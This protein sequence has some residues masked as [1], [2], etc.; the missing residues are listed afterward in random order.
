MGMQNTIRLQEEFDKEGFTLRCRSFGG[1]EVTEILQDVASARTR[2]YTDP[3]RAG[4]DAIAAY[5]CAIDP[6]WFRPI[7]NEDGF[8]DGPYYKIL[9]PSHYSDNTIKPAW[10]VEIYIPPRFSVKAGQKAIETE[11]DL[12]ELAEWYKLSEK[13]RLKRLFLWK[14]GT[15]D[16]LLNDPKVQEGL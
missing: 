3:S 14:K 10:K 15:I 9:L 2:Y 4:P 6:D 7:S 8:I 1:E 12:Q 11:E 13:Q 5:L 16:E